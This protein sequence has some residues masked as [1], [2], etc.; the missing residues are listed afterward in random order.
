MNKVCFIISS[1]GEEGSLTRSVADEKFNLV[2]KPVLEEAGYVPIRADMDNIP[3]SI[4][5]GI[6]KRII[7]SELVLADVS[8][9]NSNVFYELAVRNAT[10][11]PVIIIKRIDQTLPFDIKDIRAISVTMSDNYQWTGAMAKLKEYIK[12]AEIDPNSASE[13]ILSDFEFSIRTNNE[14]DRGSDITILL[15][16]IQSS[17]N[18][19]TN[20]LGRSVRFSVQQENEFNDL[21]FKGSFGT[22]N[23]ITI[24]SRPLVGKRGKVMSINYNILDV[25]VLL[26]KIFLEMLY[27]AVDEQTYLKQWI[28][29]DRDSRKL[30]DNIGIASPTTQHQFAT[31]GS[32]YD[33]RSLY[34]VGIK[35][36]M[37]L[38]I[39]KPGN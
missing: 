19:L 21:P 8:D 22:T 4:S 14:T 17:I 11:K 26:D 7:Q 9:E 1:I 5:R 24:D 36:G 12:N 33:N 6:I 35:P 32:N 2:F 18:T 31:L 39:R 10:K 15:K 37:N 28:L 38:I 20:K 3:N 13:S 30:F 34:Q 27:D 16:D 25:T 23:F 29:M